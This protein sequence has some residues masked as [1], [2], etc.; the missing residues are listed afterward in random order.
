M[1]LAAAA[2][3]GRFRFIQAGKV[4]DSSLQGTF[5]DDQTLTCVS[6]AAVALC[7]YAILE[8]AVDGCGPCNSRMKDRYT[9]AAYNFFYFNYQTSGT[10]SAI[11][12][13]CCSPDPRAVPHRLQGDWISC[14]PSAPGK[15]GPCVGWPKLDPGV[16]EQ[17]WMS[18][19]GGFAPPGSNASSA[20][21]GSTPA[22]PGTGAAYP[23]WC[24][25]VFPANSGNSYGLMLMDPFLEV[26][27][28]GY[29]PVPANYPGFCM[30]TT[31]HL[32]WAPVGVQ[33]DY[34]L[35]DANDPL[36]STDDARRAGYIPPPGHVT[37]GRNLVRNPA[38][39]PRHPAWPSFRTLLVSACSPQ[40][41][42]RRRARV[43]VRTVPATA[44]HPALQC[45]APHAVAKGTSTISL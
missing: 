31:H 32:P 8:L 21:N 40:A 9:P 33:L 19:L 38:P 42:R 7:T 1:R 10:T 12:A 26:A 3:A 27:A 28:F 41:V 2:A 37:Q 35:F 16:A 14:A 24:L 44:P 4:I 34:R 20:A 39:P 6:P 25:R 23:V 5:V 18:C 45:S 36:Y 13:T 15:P 29:R 30:R 43:R 17:G 11:P 22:G